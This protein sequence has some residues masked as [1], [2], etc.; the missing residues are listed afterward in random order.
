[1][2]RRARPRCETEQF[3]VICVPENMRKRYLFYILLCV[4]SVNNVLA[5]SAHEILSKTAQAF[6]KAG[7]IKAN[8]DLAISHNGFTQG[9]AS[10]EICVDKDK[11]VLITPE[12]T[13]YFDGKTQWSYL[14]DSNEVTVTEPTSEELQSLNPYALLYLYKD[15][16]GSS[17][18]TQTTY[19]GKSVYEV[20]LNALHPD[21]NVAQMTLYITRDTYQLLY[22]QATL[23][24][25][26]LNDI[27]IENYKPNVKFAQHDFV[28]DKKKYPKV[29]V[30][31]L[32]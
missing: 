32:R 27:A 20:V 13:T 3:N 18:G 15:N 30:I 22:I 31:D 2:C 19:K 17:L 1:M 5:Q 26:T 21:N 6:E 16:Y 9:H 24:D 25:G 10:G 14:A 28:F 8:F 29:E 11:F 12:A 4:C 7:G 23:R